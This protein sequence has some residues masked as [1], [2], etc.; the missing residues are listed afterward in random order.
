MG[1]ILNCLKLSVLHKTLMSLSNVFKTIIST[2]IMHLY[3][4]PIIRDITE[5]GIVL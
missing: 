4:S 2:L 3:V 5:N 1:S